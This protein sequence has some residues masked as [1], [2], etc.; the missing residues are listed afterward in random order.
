MGEL[1]GENSNQKLSH[2]NT[3]VNYC[4]SYGNIAA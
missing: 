4:H 1:G 3:V 2:V